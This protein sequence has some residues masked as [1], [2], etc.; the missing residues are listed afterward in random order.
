MSEMALLGIEVSLFA[1]RVHHGLE[2]L[3]VSMESE[4]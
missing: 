2:E 1:R 4:M 3:S